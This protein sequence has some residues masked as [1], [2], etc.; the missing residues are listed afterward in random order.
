MTADLD[1]FAKVENGVIVEYPVYRLHIVNRSQPL[2]WYTPVIDLEKPALPDFSKYVETLTLKDTYIERSFTVQPYSLNELLSIARQGKVR[3]ALPGQPTE[4]ITIADVDPAMIQQ[5]Y[6]LG[7]EYATNRLNAFSQ[8]R[9]YDN[10]DKLISYATST[11]E[12]FKTEGQR[13]LYLRD[14]TWEALV[15]YFE[16][17]VAGTLPIPKSTADIDVLLPAL[18]WE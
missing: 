9:L 1:L 12:K 2:D 4:D 3:P 15:T 18:T 14:K 11:F 16:Q 10:I 5:V 13:G 7:G 17:V 8:T 6:K